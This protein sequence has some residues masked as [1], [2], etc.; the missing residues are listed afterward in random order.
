MVECGNVMKINPRDIQKRI[1]R[2]VDIIVA[3]TPCQ[4][5]SL[6]GRRNSNDPRN[7][8][9]KQV[10]K[11]VK[12]I[13]PKMFLME[14]VGGLLTMEDGNVFLKI[15]AMFE[16]AGYSTTYKVLSASEFG[17]PQN[18]KRVFLNRY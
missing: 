15:R 3:G 8:L 10:V 7:G 16:D 5:F 2:D 14:N 17:V 11:F 9:F 12:T 13:K 6:L 18:R 1:K 4:G